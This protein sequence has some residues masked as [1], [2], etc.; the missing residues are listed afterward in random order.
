M[1]KI[2][3]KTEQI[4]ATLFSGNFYTNKTV[5]QGAGADIAPY[6]NIYYWSHARA[7]G[8]C[9]FG[10]H[11]HEGFEIM[12]FIWEGEN[13]HYDTY[14]KKWT[15]LS[16]GEFQVIQSGGGLQHAEKLIKGTRSFQIWFDPNFKSALHKNP[17]YQ[18]YSVKNWEN[19]EEN[20]F[21]VQYYIGG[22]SPANCDTEGLIIKKIEA[23]TE[24]A[25]SLPLDIS[26]HHHFYQLDRE[27]IINGMPLSMDDAAKIHGEEQVSLELGIGASLFLIETPINLSYP[28]VWTI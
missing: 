24:G 2:I 20:G 14:S 18:D 3:K 11:G 9:E 22:N 4:N 13:A 21:K 19:V 15:P 8:P 23:I 6:S 27:S 12:T 10:L 1:I 16:K 26:K 17:H 7:T 5:A 25:L 28:A